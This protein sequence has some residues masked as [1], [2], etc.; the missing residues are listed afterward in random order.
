MNRPPATPSQAPE[1]RCRLMT[2]NSARAIRKHR[3]PPIPPLGD[4]CVSHGKYLFVEADQS[5]L[6]E[7]CL[8]RLLAKSHGT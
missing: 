1:D 5:P 6:G 3:R 2:Q 7:R 4:P 8:N